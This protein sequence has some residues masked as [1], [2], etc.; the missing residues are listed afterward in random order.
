[1]GRPSW[2]SSL[3][4]VPSAEFFCRRAAPPENAIAG[5][6]PVVELALR[7]ALNAPPFGL[8]RASLRASSTTQQRQ[9]QKRGHFYL[10]KEGDISI[11]V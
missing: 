2:G 11:L 9:N 8:R 3:L 6:A 5:D 4:G 7:S 1:M 10:G